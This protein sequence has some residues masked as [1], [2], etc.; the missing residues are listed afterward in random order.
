VNNYKIVVV[1]MLSQTEVET[2]SSY[3]HDV[4]AAQGIT[5]DEVVAIFNEKL[6]LILATPSGAKISRSQ[7]IKRAKAQMDSYFANVIKVKGNPY[8]WMHM[9]KVGKIK[10]WNDTILNECEN[11]FLTGKLEDLIKDG[12]VMTMEVDG[13]QVPVS[14]IDKMEDEKVVITKEGKIAPA[15]Q[16]GNPIIISKVVAGKPWE[17]GEK[18]IYRDNRLKTMGTPE[19]EYNRGYGHILGHSLEIKI[20]G[21]AFPKDH[22]ED[23]RIFEK[24]VGYDQADENS[25]NFFFKKFE[26]FM[27]YVGNFD[28]D[29]KYTTEYKFA[30]KGKSGMNGKVADYKPTR[31]LD[32][33]SEEDIPIDEFL[34]DKLGALWDTYHDKAFIPKVYYLNELKTMHESTLTLKDG[35]VEKSE[36]GYDKTNYDAWNILSTAVA[37]GEN[38]KGGGWHYILTD[39]AY[40]GSVRAFPDKTV[41]K[42]AKYLPGPCLLAVH[43]SRNNMRYDATAKGDVLDPDNADIKMNV[44]AIVSVMAPNVEIVEIG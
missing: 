37:I 8:V 17:N 38:K 11:K 13:K 26:P 6:T 1:R 15:D 24:K 40:K 2:Y 32:D 34:E 41:L 12:L 20:V 44:G 33:G 31:K 19:G 28:I 14:R 10:D 29:T 35:K 5:Y 30:F 23:F 9:G 27:W 7:Q 22:P 4:A 18:P 25:E 43:T 3:F 21:V 39:S 16:E 42:Q 36:S